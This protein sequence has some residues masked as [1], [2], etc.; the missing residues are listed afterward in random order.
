MKLSTLLVF[1]I[2]FSSASFS[3]W[4]AVGNGTNNSSHG[5]LT[6][7][8]KLVNL[9]SFNNPC[10]RVGLWDGSNWSCIT[11]TMGQVARAGV[12]WNGKLVVVGDFWN[13]QQP[14]VGCNGVA[15]Y[16]DVNNVWLPLGGGVN[17]DVLCATVFNGDLI[18]GGD[19]TTA[20]GVPSSRVVRYNEVSDTWESIGSPTDFDN[21]VRCMTEFQGELWVGGDFNNVGG[22]SPS[23]GVVKWDPSAN[24][25]AG[26][27]VGGNS[28]V[29]LVGGVNETVRVLYVNPNDGNL[30]M[31]GE[32]PELIDGNAGITDYNMSGIAMYDGSDWTS[33]GSGLNEYCRAIHEYNGNLIAGGYFTT[34]GGVPAQKIAKWN[35]STWSAMGGGFDGV[36]IDEYV[37]SAMVWN[38]IFFAGGAYTQ[39]EGGPMNFI[40]QWY[41]APSNPPVANINLSSTTICANDCLTFADASTNSPTSWSWSFP[42]ATTTTST[43]QNPSNI[44]YSNPGNYT[45]SLQ[46]CNGSGCGTTT[47]NITVTATPSVTVNSTSICAGSSV[48]LNATPSAGGGTYLW[49]PGNETTPSI[50][51]SPG[52][53]TT[54]SVEYTI[55][56]CTSTPA[57]S[58]V[59][60]TPS[61]TVTVN[62]EN[63]CQGS[64]VTL[65][66]TPSAG[67]GTYTW[68]PGGQTSNSISVTPTSSTSYQ[69]QYSLNGC[70]TTE[71]SNVNVNPTYQLN[72]NISACQNELVTYPDGTNETIT[73]STSHTSLLTTGAG[74]DST[75]VTNVTMNNTYNSNVNVSACI[76]SSYSYPDGYTEVISANTSHTSSL[77]TTSG[78]DSI[79]VTA[80]TAV[81]A[82][83]LSE[84]IDACQNTQV[85]YPDGTTQTVTT[86]TSHTSLLTSSS[87]CDSTIVTNVTVHSATNNNASATVCTGTSYIFPDG[88][89]QVINSTTTQTS[90]LTSVFGCDSIIVTTVTAAPAYNQTQSETV[91]QGNTITYPD[92][93]N[94]VINGNTS[95]TS[96]LS[97]VNGC[98]SVIV[99]NVSMSPNYSINQNI[100]VCTG[101]SY[102]YPDGTISTNITVNENHTSLLTTINGCDST[103][104]TYLNVTTTLSSSESVDVCSGDSYTYPDGTTANNI[105]SNT[106][107]V[108]NLISSG[109]CDSL[110]TTNVSV[111]PLPDVTTSVANN[112][113]TA[114]QQGAIYQWI[115]CNNGNAPIAGATGVSFTP[116]VNGQYAVQVTLNG[117]TSTSSC[118]TISTIGIEEIDG[119]WASIYPNPTSELL[120]VETNVNDM[121]DFQIIDMQGRLVMKGSLDSNKSVNVKNLAPGSYSIELTGDSTF[122]IRFVKE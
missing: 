54:Y 29:D 32:F 83:N 16:D 63:I 30:Y 111:T 91:C 33:L 78:C 48:T 85:T 68:T 115:D 35:G 62:S 108:S 77:T 95:H 49:S 101:S 41:E 20:S 103:V 99:T 23:D 87:G 6:W 1:L 26:A 112:V 98:D 4:T 109:G 86:N 75:I 72:E 46:A 69:V 105:T 42:G 100:D 88:T 34:A 79:I 47:M 61:P 8:G 122:R 71:T 102:T 50:S 7:D 19:F 15:M 120:K 84:N 44:C 40:A 10:T 76:G 92:G 89:S 104:I 94:E 3:Q 9:G 64:T 70:S 38:G 107:H 116:T 5:M 56:G 25:G 58:T 118:V 73:G 97:S 110:V 106:T 65:T 53:S 82:Y 60:V 121:K 74:C 55:N 2:A 18:I 14:C 67:G 12:V 21:D 43:D 113:I 59:T 57:I 17:N 51:V 80:V 90:S 114:N 11:G 45:I 96:L 27:W 39:A 37:K 119:Y 117:C 66:A 24:S 28:G 81:S 31:G 22:N 13:T 93:V 52:S 36:G